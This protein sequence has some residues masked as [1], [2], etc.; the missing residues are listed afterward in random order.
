MRAAWIWVAMAVACS[1]QSPPPPPSARAPRQGEGPA[2][3]TAAA[4]DKPADAQTLAAVYAE[5]LDAV[6]AA[7]EKELDATDP[8]SITTYEDGVTTLRRVTP[9]AHMELIGETLAKHGIRSRELATWMNDARAEADALSKKM[10]ARLA[11]RQ[12]EVR[13]VMERV[14]E[15]APR[16]DRARIL[17]QLQAVDDAEA[18]PDAKARAW[19]PVDSLDALAEIA[20]EA[21][22]G[23]GVVI[24]VWAQWC[25][26]CKELDKVAFVD[27]QAARE[28]ARFERVRI[29]VTEGGPKSETILARLGAQSL[30]NVLVFGSARALAE[31]LATPKPVEPA[32]R[33]ESAV[34]GAELAKILA[35]VETSG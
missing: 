6:A 21:G 23:R 31:Q 33:V 12:P 10:E 9:S 11:A 26:P 19:T 28:L 20:D 22:Q 29:D 32:A 34:S 16:Q 1:G 25:L 18:P 13:A 4:P 30:P 5:A 17:A 14:A 3:P 15:L 8:A 7:V 2:G 24:D 35:G 27:P